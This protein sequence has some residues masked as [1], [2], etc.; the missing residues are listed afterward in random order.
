[1]KKKTV[2]DEKE[3]GD[4]PGDL[5]DD[6]KEFIRRKNIQNKVLRDLIEKLK[7]TK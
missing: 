4:L 1:M 7:D 3:H 5:N 2:K 6:L